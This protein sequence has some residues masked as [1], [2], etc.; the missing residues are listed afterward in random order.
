MHQLQVLRRLRNPE[1]R[2]P[3]RRSSARQERTLRDPPCSRPPGHVVAYGWRALHGWC[4]FGPISFDVSY[5]S[6]AMFMWRSIGSAHGRTR[7]MP[8][9]PMTVLLEL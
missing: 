6:E 5:K 7:R 1:C 8:S 4:G 9:L 3:R 2:F